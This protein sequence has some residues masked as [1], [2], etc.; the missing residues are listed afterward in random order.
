MEKER[1]KRLAFQAKIAEAKSMRDLMLK[2]AQVKRMEQE[3]QNKKLELEQ[4]R[5][6]EEE[7]L[8]EKKHNAEKRE[9]EKQA[10]RLIIF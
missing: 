7:I 9:M 1:Q 3:N 10:A 6:L 5:K 8:L 4:K 2:E